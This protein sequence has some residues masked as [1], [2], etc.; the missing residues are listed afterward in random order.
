[1]EN[2]MARTVGAVD[3]ADGK[4]LYLIFDRTVDI[5][6]R[7]L[8][9][10]KGAALQWDDEQT[11]EYVEPTNA[12]QTEEAV[13]VL[14]HLGFDGDERFIFESRA[15]R[16]AMWLTG[17]ASKL[18]MYD[19]NLRASGGDDGYTPIDKPLN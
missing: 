14:T 10:T 6:L 11:L 3:F 15:S 5:A 19:E 7:P 12:V 1:M 9:E 18:E 2:I 4:R 17:P 16:K 13:E 8:F